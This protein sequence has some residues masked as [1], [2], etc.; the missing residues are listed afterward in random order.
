[1]SAC[2]RRL[3]DCSVCLRPIMHAVSGRADAPYERD[4]VSV[5][6]PPQDDQP[7]RFEQRARL[8]H[9][10]CKLLQ[11]AGVSRGGFYAYLGSKDARKKKLAKAVRLRQPLTLKAGR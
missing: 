3:G 4:M 2:A 7:A 1:M 5:Y 10:R 6:I 9:S 11:E 8:I